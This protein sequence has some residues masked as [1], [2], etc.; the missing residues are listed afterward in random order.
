MSYADL[1]Q[2]DLEFTVGDYVFLKVSPMKGVTRFRKKSKLAL[3]YIGPFEVIDRVRAIAYRLELLTSLSH[4]HLVFHISMLRKYVPDPS[5]V[6]QPNIVELNENL[7]FKE[8]PIAIVDYQ[9]R[10]LTLKQIPMVK[11]RKMYRGRRAITAPEREVPDEV[12]AQDEVP[13]LRR[14][15]RRQGR[16]PRAAQIEE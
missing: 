2:K 10:Q 9:M 13:A 3:R 16:R 7:T 5:H 15:G 11:V 1:Q 8:Q 14:Q 12:S 6:L 4:V